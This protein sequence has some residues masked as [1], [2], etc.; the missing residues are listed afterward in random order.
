MPRLVVA[1][2]ADE[3]VGVLQIGRD[4]DLLYGDKLRREPAL[5]ADEFAKFA[6][7]QLVDSLEAVFHGSDE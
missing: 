7:D 4:I 3:D 2:D 1:D 5:A 6:F